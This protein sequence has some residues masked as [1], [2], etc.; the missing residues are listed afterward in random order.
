MIGVLLMAHGGPDTLED[1]E[2]F[3]RHVLKDRPLSPAYLDE[4][5]E[6]YR[7]IGGKS[8]LLATTQRQAA[9]LE[10]RLR[11]EGVPAKVYIGMRHW[12]PFIREAVR[13]MA[14]DGVV[15]GV[16]LC[17]TPQDSAWSVGAYFAALDDAQKAE[18]TSIPLFPVRHWHD[19]P[20]LLDAFAAKIREALVRFSRPEAVTL[21]FTAHSLPAGRQGL[22]E[23]SGAQGD[24][25]PAQ[26][27]ETVQGIL[28]ML[29]G[30]HRWRLAYQSVPGRRFDSASGKGRTQGKWLGPEVEPTLREL[31]EEGRRDVLAVPIGFVADH[32]ETLYDLDILHRGQAEALGIRFERTA[33][34]NDDPLLIE[35]LAAIVRKAL[36]LT[37]DS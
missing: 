19:E 13:A 8:P 15:R 1:V 11:S 29:G 9:A 6:R 16:A 22:P 7:L 32:V 28:R 12:H 17:L 10:T 18:G 5:R 2:P 30:T 23:P 33:S 14:A 35:A 4:V 36:L 21:L 34:L 24:P 26:V 3:L 27:A 31:A 25:Y 20:L 37:S